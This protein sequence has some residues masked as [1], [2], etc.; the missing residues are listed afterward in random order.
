MVLFGGYSYP[1]TFNDTWI[2]NISTNKWTK[3][4]PSNSPPGRFWHGMTYDCKRGE[5]IIFGG[6]DAE[7]RLNDTWTYNLTGNI[8]KNAAPS[9]E[10]PHR[11]NFAMAYNSLHDKVVM[12]SGG[13]DLPVN[14]TWIYDRGSNE[15]ITAGPIFGPPWLA[16]YAMVYDGIH[17]EIVLSGGQYY[18]D[19]PFE[20]WTFRFTN[21]YFGTYTSAPAN[22]PIAAFFG[23]LSWSA[24]IPSQTSV[25]FQF[26]GANT[27]DNLLT[28]D[29][30]GPDA[31]PNSYY[32]ASG[33]Q[34]RGIDGCQW[35]QYRAYFNTEN[36]AVTPK[37]SN[38]SVNYNLIHSVKISCPVSG[39]NWSGSQN[40]TWTAND[41]DNDHLMFDVF[42]ENHSVSI[43][44][45]L[46]LPDGTSSLV[47]NASL[48]PNGTYHI[49]IVAKDD[50]PL[51]PLTVTALSND[52]TVDN[53]PPL[54]PNHPPHVWLINPLNNSIINETSIR[55]SW[56][57]TDPENDPLEY[58][59]R[60]TESLLD[61]VTAEPG[62]TDD[63]FL[64]QFDLSDNTTY[65]WTV[66]AAD[67]TNNH[68]DIPVGIWTFTVRLLAS[69]TPVNHPPRITS[70]PR[71][72]V[73]AGD[74]YQYN[75]TAIDED[76]TVLTYSL[77]NGPQYMSIDNATGRL[78][79]P[80]TLS[81]VGNHTVTIRVTDTGGA[82]D[83]QTFAITV[84]AP[85]ALP[86][87]PTCAITS[88]ANGSKASGRILIRGT[89]T[90]GTLP[91]T[92]IQLRL[93]GGQWRTAV[94]LGNWSITLDLSKSPNGHHVIEARSFDG[95]LYSDTASIQVDI[96]NPEPST[97]TGE[98][99]WLPVGLIIAIA[100][101]V[102][103]FLV[104]RKRK[105]P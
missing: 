55:L 42:L 14:D 26:R 103:I 11:Y 34:I 40:I 8:W 4:N 23:S 51:I 37:L 95:S 70:L 46:D 10:A 60:L 36:I 93:D 96:R 20:T 94:G 91:L 27:K 62:K 56:L 9:G 64:D 7:H 85:P 43:P 83:N 80:T 57:G 22:T 98:P 104:S 13:G 5:E 65:F 52:F 78:R 39:E 86:Q 54:P 33:Q 12:A 68:T 24:S 73:T 3:M 61:L 71:T 44:L 47:W 81:D 50:N 17:D 28:K 75:V 92:L 6:E 84:L 88:P 32:E 67:G 31:T 101:G 1:T 41:V 19:S 49:R 105:A 76:F 2:Y 77:I 72:A 69:P 29:F 15:W 102:G 100:A 53:Q 35:F 97:T 63:E 30:L 25:R 82:S 48:V 79:W 59:V 87:K 38:V 58:S 74:P 89:A 90:N 66:D 45:A 18:L 99:P 16:G 21:H